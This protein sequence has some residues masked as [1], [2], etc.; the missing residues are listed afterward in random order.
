[1]DKIQT[2]RL[3]LR[4]FVF[5][6]F[7]L[8]PIIGLPL[9]VLALVDARDVHRRSQLPWNPADRYLIIGTVLG[10]IGIIISFLAICLAAAIIYKIA[11]D[12]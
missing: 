8:M 10:P 5:S 6:L 1:M 2:I 11:T 3:S 7:G 4:C 9:A 12:N